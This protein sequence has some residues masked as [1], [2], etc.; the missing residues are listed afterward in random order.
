MRVLLTGAS[1]FVGSHLYPELVRAGHEPVCLTR[2]LD[3]ARSRWPDRE[4]REGDLDN[5]VALR[6][7]LSGCHAAYY[8]VHGMADHSADF[9][10]HER[11]TAERFVRAAAAAGLDRIIY[12]GGFEPQGPPTEH[13]A[14]RLEVG[15]IL[16][17]GA[18]PTL[19]LRA[20]MIV[21]TGSISWLMVRDLAA[22]LPAMTLPAWLKSRTQPVAMD[23]VMAALVT[24]LSLPVPQGGEWYDLPGPDILTGRQVLEGVADAM[25]LPRPLTVEVPVLTPWLSSH[26]VHFVTRAEWS[27]AREIVVGMAH[28]F[29]AHDNRFWS[30]AGITP[31]PF[32]EAARRALAAEAAEGEIPG[33]WGGVERLMKR[34]VRRAAAP[35]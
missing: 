28:D 9:R 19:E 16:R 30:M 6:Q 14:S 17:A 7:A 20:S 24:A 29:L 26:W 25:G 3:S 15:E 32:R 21:G 8:L 10:R 1:G 33:F 12:L 5:E 31:L 18:V 35:V 2:R 4:W 22:R 34:R 11:E 23:D 13:L 27:V